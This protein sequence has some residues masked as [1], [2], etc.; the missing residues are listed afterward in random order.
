[1]EGLNK[2][3]V[4]EYQILVKDMLEG[5]DPVEEPGELC[6]ELSK[7]YSNLIRKGTQF[8]FVEAFAIEY[9]NLYGN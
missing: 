3:L 7:K 1:M 5:I 4:Q 9:E 2:K 6:A 8:E